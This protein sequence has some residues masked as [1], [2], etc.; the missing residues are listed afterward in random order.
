M[1][2]QL[3]SPSVSDPRERASKAEVQYLLWPG[4]SHI[5]SIFYLSQR[6]TLRQYGKGLHKAMDTWKQGSLGTIVEGGYY[7]EDI[8]TETQIWW[9]TSRYM[10]GLLYRQGRLT[11]CGFQKQNSSQLPEISLELHLYYFTFDGKEMFQQ[12][13]RSLF[14]NQYGLEKLLTLIFFLRGAGWRGESCNISPFKNKVLMWW[15]YT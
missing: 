1:T 8:T 7:R 13:I 12:N 2:W 6:P 9:L 14:L 15:V 5:P 4:R 10:K 3:A 11:L